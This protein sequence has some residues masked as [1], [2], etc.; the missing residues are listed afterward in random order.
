[1]KMMSKF[2]KFHVDIPSRYEH[3]SPQARLK[4]EKRSIIL[5]RKPKPGPNLVG[6]STNVPSEVFMRCSH[7]IPLY[8]F[9]YHDEK[10]QNGH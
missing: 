9:Q 10:C 1:M 3:I 8:F 4:F 7:K 2:A 5:Y 6:D